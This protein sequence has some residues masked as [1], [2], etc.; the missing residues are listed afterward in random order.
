MFSNPTLFFSSASGSGYSAEVLADSPVCYYRL[1]EASGTTMNDSSGN[2]LT[3]SYTN[4]TL[5]TTGLI[6][7]DSD[8]AVTFNGT[9]A[10]GETPDNAL[11]DV[12]DISVDAWIKTSTT[13]VIQMIA[14]RDRSG[15][16][17]QRQFQLRLTTGG[18]LEA[19]V[20]GNGGT[21]A[22]TLTD[23]VNIADGSKHHVGFSYDSTSFAF[24]LYV[25]GSNVQSTTGSA[26]LDNTI[27]WPLNIAVNQNNTAS[28]NSYFNGVV[29]EFAMYG[30]VIGDTR[31]LA[32]YNAGA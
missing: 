24:K 26:A 10:Y 18:F 5:G 6:A 15:T 11:L 28:Y 7:G 2:N 1:G 14:T 22:L 20:F 25:D 21:P 16:S 27:V 17:L 4:A 8:T 3:G 12:T 13:G 29:D 9:S 32:H 23:N 31:F 19:I 30:T